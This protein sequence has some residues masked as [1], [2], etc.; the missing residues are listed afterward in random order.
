M[1]S[2]LTGYLSSDLED[3]LT[4]PRLLM[5]LAFFSF[6]FLM[7]GVLGM[8]TVCCA[9]LLDCNCCAGGLVAQTANTAAMLDTALQHNYRTAVHYLPVS[10]NSPNLC[11]SSP[12]VTCSHLACRSF[13]LEISWRSWEVIFVPWHIHLHLC[14]PLRW[15]DKLKWKELGSSLLYIDCQTTALWKEYDGT[16]LRSCRVPQSQTS[17]FWCG[18]QFFGK[19]WRLFL[20]WV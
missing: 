12:S 1:S 11:L 13:Q 16:G 17:K 5:F 18:I 4:L 15:G 8:V 7:L 9:L 14:S 6:A 10:N 3:L 19:S 20:F 2:G